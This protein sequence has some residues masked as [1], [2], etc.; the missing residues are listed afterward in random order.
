MAAG[1]EAKQSPQSWGF[2]F[3]ITFDLFMF[4]F[5]GMIYEETKN[6]SWALPC[7]G[8]CSMH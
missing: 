5:H 2:S 6:H 4:V 8:E 3:G 1:A 7:C